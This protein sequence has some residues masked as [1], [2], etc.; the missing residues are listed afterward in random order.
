MHTAVRLNQK[1]REYSDKSQ[2]VILNLPK[3]PHSS[4]GLHNYIEYLQVLTDKLERVLLV[5]GSGK[6]VITMY[7]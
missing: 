4:S 1:L 5:R 2:L 3:P 6:E 7:S